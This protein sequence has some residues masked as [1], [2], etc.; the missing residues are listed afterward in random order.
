[1]ELVR[2]EVKNR[3][4]LFGHP[5]VRVIVCVHVQGM[6]VFA[7]PAVSIVNTKNNSKYYYYYLLLIFYN[8][9]II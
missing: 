8:D 2:V 4:R 1:M 3:M 9:M 7:V 5:R 6:H